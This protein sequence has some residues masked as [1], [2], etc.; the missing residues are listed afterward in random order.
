VK[1]IEKEVA[2]DLNSEMNTVITKQWF[3]TDCCHQKRQFRAGDLATR[4]SCVL[5][6]VA[7]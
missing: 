5:I 1:I 2:R 3:E 4:G 7:E 6:K